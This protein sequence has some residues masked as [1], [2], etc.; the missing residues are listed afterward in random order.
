RP[1][2]GRIGRRALHA[3]RDD[4]RGFP[5]ERTGLARRSLG[6]VS[7]AAEIAE[8]AKDPSAINRKPI[9]DLC[10]LRELRGKRLRPTVYFRRGH[11]NRSIRS[12]ASEAGTAVEIDPRHES[13]SADNRHRTV[14]ER[15][16]RTQQRAATGARGTLPVSAALAATTAG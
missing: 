3:H 2:P 13:G 5:L 12:L 15:R 7:L 9:E 6:T 1:D 16:R 10:E 11:P 8:T 4:R 14:D